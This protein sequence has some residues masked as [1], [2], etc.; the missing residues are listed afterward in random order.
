MSFDSISNSSGVR[1]ATR[2]SST[3]SNTLS[4][5]AMDSAGRKASL[6]GCLRNRRH[7]QRGIHVEPLDQVLFAAEAVDETI[8]FEPI[9]AMIVIGGRFG[10]VG[11]HV[12]RAEGAQNAQCE[13]RKH[14]MR[15]PETL[16]LTES[17]PLDL[18]EIRVGLRLEC[19]RLWAICGGR[20]PRS[21]HG[22]QNRVALASRRDR[23]VSFKASQ[24]GASPL[25]Y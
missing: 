24:T 11:E 5:T 25:I 16:C 9:V 22:C 6:V 21:R 17:K 3:K 2:A 19:G 1:S 10:D 8:V 15:I 7:P 12:G 4:S 23:S 14:G 13:N 20:G 18:G